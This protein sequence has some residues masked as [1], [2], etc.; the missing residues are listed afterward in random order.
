MSALILTLVGVDM[1]SHYEEE[2]EFNKQ[3]PELQ[4]ATELAVIRDAKQTRVFAAKALVRRQD[5]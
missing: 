1:A 2:P 3:D 4:T 5:P